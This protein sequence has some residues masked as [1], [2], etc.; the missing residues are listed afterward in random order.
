[1]E[2]TKARNLASSAAR[3]A[4][5]AVAGAV[6]RGRRSGGPVAQTLTIAVSV[7]DVYAACRDAEVLD[8]VFSAGVE[9]VGV[10]FEAP[11]RYRWTVAG[12]TVETELVVDPHGMSFTEVG[13]GQR[14]TGAGPTG[15]GPAEGS[16]AEARTLLSVEVHPAPQELGSEVRFVLDLPVPE[17]VAGALAFTV[18]YRLRALLQT[19]EVPTLAEVPSNRRAKGSDA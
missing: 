18:L 16:P 3:S 6:H 15:E 7:G 10:T 8:R 2:T 19:G 5:R 12:T 13:S 14:S 4:G 11:R 9:D 1:M 17:K